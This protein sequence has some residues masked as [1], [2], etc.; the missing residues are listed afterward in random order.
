[1]ELKIY[2]VYPSSFEWILEIIHSKVFILCSGNLNYAICPRLVRSEINLIDDRLDVWL[3]ETDGSQ[4][5][6]TLLFA[7]MLLLI[8]HALQ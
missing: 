3:V 7:S 8:R 4:L 6:I 2:W 1:M 5:D